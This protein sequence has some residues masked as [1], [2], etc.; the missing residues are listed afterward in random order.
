MPVWVKLTMGPG[1]RWGLAKLSFPKT[2]KSVVGKIGEE[3]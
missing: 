2:T 3:D 1:E